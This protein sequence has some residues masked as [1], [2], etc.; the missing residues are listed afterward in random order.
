MAEISSSVR[1]G[2]EYE[3]AIAQVEH[4][5]AGA[6]LHVVRSF[7][8]PT[9]HSALD[10]AACSCPHHGT[11]YCDCRLV[12]LLVYGPDN[13]PATLLMHGRDHKASFALA[14]SPQNTVDPKLEAL[15][16]SLL[17]QAHIPHL[18]SSA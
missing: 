12:V 17:A 7:D 2:I 10:G 4:C 18:S 1:T 9:A 11:R 16:A 13:T 6:G 5:L 14:G 15:I 3:A 8:F